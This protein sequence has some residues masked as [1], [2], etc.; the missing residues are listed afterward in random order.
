MSENE[1]NEDV[2]PDDLLS[3]FRGKGIFPILIFTVLVHGVVL[4]GSSVPWMMETL[5]TSVDE[6]ASEE[7]RMKEAV[8]EASGSLR[9][10]ADK[11]GLHPEE[12]SSQ[13]TKKE[14]PK[15]AATQTPTDKEA[16]ATGTPS[17]PTTPTD[18]EEP[19]SSIEQEL[20]AKATG[21]ALPAIPQE[22][23]EDLFK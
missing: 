16:P 12:L 21:P 11:Y 23:E 15:P 18:P 9:E 14:K 13:F 20:E 7:E 17:A 4:L 8:R 5:F 3:D 2:T 6:D 10:I 19:K 1:Y 22:E